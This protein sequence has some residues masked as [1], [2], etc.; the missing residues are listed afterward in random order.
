M[1]E[2]N[3][4]EEW[5]NKCKRDF[6]KN[7]SYGHQSYMF[8]YL[9]DYTEYYDGYK[10]MVFDRIQKTTI[11]ENHLNMNLGIFKKLK[12]NISKVSTIT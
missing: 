11:Q 9:W 7:K 6:E 3:L 10:R 4:D 1:D 2:T 5:E 8:E 12:E